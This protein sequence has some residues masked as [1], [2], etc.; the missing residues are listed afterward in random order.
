MESMGGRDNDR[1]AKEINMKGKIQIY[2]DR[3]SEYRWRVVATNGR[4]TGTSGGD[5]YKTIAGCM[6]GLNSVKKNI[7]TAEI[8]LP[9]KYRSGYAVDTWAQAE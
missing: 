9:K 5:G 1:N 4:I 6:K 2:K 8:E 7:A 3:R